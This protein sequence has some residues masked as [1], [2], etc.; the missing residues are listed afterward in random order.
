MLSEVYKH[1]YQVMHNIASEKSV[2]SLTHYS[3]AT[4]DQ[5]K[6]MAV[7]ETDQKKKSS[8]GASRTASAPPPPMFTPPDV[9][10][11]RSHFFP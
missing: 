8:E 6:S 2:E 7:I 4:R 5:Q 1:P 11:T 10:S 9:D 3:M